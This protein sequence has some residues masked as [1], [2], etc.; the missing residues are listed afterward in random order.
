MEDQQLTNLTWEAIDMD[1]SMCSPVQPVLPEPDFPMWVP[2][3]D[4]KD[5]TRRILSFS[6]SHN[7]REKRNFKL[8][9]F[10]HSL[11]KIACATRRLRKK[12]H[13]PGD[14]PDPKIRPKSK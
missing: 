13:V 6:L 9:F 10:I 14:F 4:D 2:L 8:P 1:L 5:F 3:E 11:K 7:S 12:W